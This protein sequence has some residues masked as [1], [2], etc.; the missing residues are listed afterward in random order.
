VDGKWLI[1]RVEFRNQFGLS[2]DNHGRLYHGQ[3]NTLMRADVFNPGFFLRNAN[4][5]LKMSQLA[6]EFNVTQDHCFNVKTCEQAVFPVRRS[7]DIRDGYLES[8]GPDID[9]D[10]FAIRCTAACGHHFYRGNHFGQE[11]NAFVVDPGMHFVKAIKIHREEGIPYGKHVFTDQEIVASP[12]T[13]FRPVDLQTAPDGSLY[14][15]DMYHGINQHKV[16]MSAH[17][18]AFILKHHLEQPTGLGRISRLSS[19]EN[20]LSLI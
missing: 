13:R 15:A 4:L 2:T 12:D 16:F 20:D 17:L 6:T 14:I 18:K 1:E 3:Q 8:K 7:R 19:K 11:M 10:G 5:N 9:E